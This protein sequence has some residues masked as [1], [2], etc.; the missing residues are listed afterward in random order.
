MNEY[1]VLAQLV[2]ESVGNERVSREKFEEIAVQLAAD[3]AKSD[4]AWAAYLS[5]LTQAG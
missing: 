1:Q 4:R 2:L 5:A 3:L